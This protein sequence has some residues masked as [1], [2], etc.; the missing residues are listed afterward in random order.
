M[1]NIFE[2]VCATAQGRETFD[3]NAVRKVRQKFRLVDKCD[4]CRY[5]KVVS[6]DIS[7]SNS[8]SKWRKEETGSKEK[9][10]IG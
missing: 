1:T 6:N 4:F 3:R 2:T 8:I 5:A 9:H 10:L 7:Y